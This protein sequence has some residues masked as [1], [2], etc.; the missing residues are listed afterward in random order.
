M[1]TP[2]RRRIRHARR[3]TGYGL[4]ILLIGLALLVGVANQ[5]LPM[6][7]RHPEKIAAWLS[8]R[9]GEPVSF[10]HA[11]AEWT[12]R[13]PRFI[14]DGLHVGKGETQLDIG[15][16]QLQVAMY[17]GLLPGQPL[18]EL[19]IRDLALTLVQD[20]EGRWKV[21]GLPGQDAT[22]DP[23]DRLEGFGELQIEKARLA[24]RAP[25]LKIEMSMPRIDARVRVD[26]P[27]RT[28]GSFSLGR[29]G[30]SSVVGR[31][32]V[33]PSTPRWAVVGWRQ[34][35]VARALV[36]RAGFGR[37]EAGAGHRRSRAVDRTA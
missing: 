23:L 16:A 36:S 34:E 19:K 29:S 14:L 9:V 22:I 31:S 10:S 21:I 24:V 15:R 20:Q 7:E 8:A 18:T 5:L 1:T 4:L 25:K 2:L 3:W 13:G 12:R 26:G 30:R 17:S 33:S 6:V 35:T 11:S 37:A 28:G 32:R 27:R